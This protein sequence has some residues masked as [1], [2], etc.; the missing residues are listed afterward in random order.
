M[1]VVLTENEY[2]ILKRNEA[3]LK[4]IKDTLRDS[5]TITFNNDGDMVRGIRMSVKDISIKKESIIDLLLADSVY[6]TEL[7]R[8]EVK[9]I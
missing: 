2:E 1:Q 3:E 4:R 9:F 7:K 6:K 5:L 8:Q